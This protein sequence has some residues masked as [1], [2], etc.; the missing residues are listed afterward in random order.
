MKYS[1][2]FEFYSIK[3]R[4]Y[5]SKEIC[6]MIIKNPIKIEKQDNGRMRYWGWS[7]EFKK[8]VRVVVLE[9]NETILTAHFD[10]NFKQKED[11]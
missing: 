11:L 7:E 10:R 6:E 3:I 4:P 1:D 5:L 8:F 9:D 2:H